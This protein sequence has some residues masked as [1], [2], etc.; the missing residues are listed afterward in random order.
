MGTFTAAPAPHANSSEPCSTPE[1]RQFDFWIGEWDSYDSSGK[2]Q[3]HASVE[4]IQGGCVLFQS[5][6]GTSGDTGNSFS[7]YD[8][9][10]K[11]WNQ[12]LVSNH[13]TLLPFE[14]YWQPGTMLLL[15]SHLGPDGRNQLHRI[16]WKPGADGV[17]QRWDYSDDG[18][19]TWIV[20]YEGFL[21]RT[22]N[23]AHI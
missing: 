19:Q 4:K 20:N 17:Y 10:R 16:I 14:G 18:G 9:T 2:F 6:F 3:G 1:Y 12:T 22:E 15:G 23:R 8:A 21:R 7:I 13:G 5:W 11:I